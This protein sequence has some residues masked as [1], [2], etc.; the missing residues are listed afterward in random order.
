MLQREPCYCTEKI[1]AFSLQC[2][3]GQPYQ[4]GVKPLLPQQPQK[5]TS[6]TLSQFPSYKN[7]VFGG[8]GVAAYKISL[9]F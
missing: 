8:G 3:R 6:F 4:M 5:S 2:T 9:I 1:A 7:R